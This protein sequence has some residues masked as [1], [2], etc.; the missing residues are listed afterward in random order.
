MF[1]PLKEELHPNVIG[2]H[3]KAKSGKDELASIFKESFNF[4]PV[5]FASKV[6]QFALQYFELTSE[7]ANEKK[8]KDSR[9]ILQGIGNSVRHNII[10][11]ENILSD[12]AHMKNLK[13][14][15]GFPG[16]VEEMAI[17]EFDIKPE[18]LKRK[19]KYNKIVLN[20]IFNLW[21]QNIY[22][23]KNMCYDEVAMSYDS[24]LIWV[25]YLIAQIEKLSCKLESTNKEN[26]TDLRPTFIVT[27]V[28]YKN[29][30]T[31]VERFR[32]GVIIKILRVDKPEIE[33]GAEHDSEI[34]LDEAKDWFYIVVNDHKAAWAE[35]LLLSSIN[36][37]R[38]MNH[39]NMFSAADKAAFK[40]K[41]AV[42]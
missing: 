2:I 36:I 24:S 32:H 6:K 23:F 42:V 21:R 33:T 12:E 17:M 13:G 37:V 22:E 18:N 20:G 39:N 34:E 30:K 8:T 15:T 38:K 28:R 35:L 29:E 25:N 19:L 9:R 7:Q 3:G 5:A 40:I 10:T 26:G 41:T 11:I 31:A 4:I 14:V 27:D 1:D 16:W